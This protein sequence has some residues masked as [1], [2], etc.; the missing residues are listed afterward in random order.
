MIRSAQDLPPPV[1]EV[2]RR[3]KAAHGRVYLVTVESEGR[4]VHAILRALTKAEVDQL[5]TEHDELRR[6]E[7]LLSKSVL[8]PSLAEL[9]TWAAGAVDA[10][11]GSVARISG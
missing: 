11:M 4:E 10:I 2:V 5:E 8:H 9:D 6:Q 1:Q 3:G 7:D